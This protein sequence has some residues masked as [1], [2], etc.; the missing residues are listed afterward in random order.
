MIEEEHK[1]ALILEKVAISDLYSILDGN[2]DFEKMPIL[3]SSKQI[4]EKA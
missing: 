2:S 1:S 4:M 3:G